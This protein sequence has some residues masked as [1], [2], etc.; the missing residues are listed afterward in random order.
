MALKEVGKADPE[1]NGINGL[2]DGIGLPN[3][4]FD[5]FLDP[6][7]IRQPFKSIYAETSKPKCIRGAG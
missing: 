2:P 3:G 4:D 7:D 1:T 6:A 5:E